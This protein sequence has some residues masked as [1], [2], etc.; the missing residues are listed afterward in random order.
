MA[1]EN[2][3]NFLGAPK[4]EKENDNP[5]QLPREELKKMRHL[6][7]EKV[8]NNPLSYAENFP[9][10]EEFAKAGLME[11]GEE[12][13]SLETVLKIPAEKVVPFGGKRIENSF[14]NN[15]TGAITEK[16]LEELSEKYRQY[17]SLPFNDRKKGFTFLEIQ[18]EK[19]L[20]KKIFGAKD[21]V[22]GLDGDI[23][24]VDALGRQEKIYDN[25][26]QPV[27]NA[28]PES[29]PDKISAILDNELKE[30]PSS[31]LTEQKNFFAEDFNKNEPFTN[32]EAARYFAK[33]KGYLDLNQVP[34]F[35]PEV[36]SIL[37]E[38]EGIIS[39]VGLQEKNINEA[40]AAVLK[41]FKSMTYF[42]DDVCKKMEEF[43][44]IAA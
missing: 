37:Q 1:F 2:I 6:D 32:V 22:F 7:P 16:T 35:S 30:H 15:E 18:Q 34:Y 28:R 43:S 17:L 41:N 29:E 31:L 42:N 9:P 11:K 39:L 27:E 20:F 14:E 3:T 21:V 44:P 26:G 13:G 8:S 36:L 33:Q 10:E 5:D 4:K 23:F 19:E 38:R 24:K 12:I 25:P 40:T